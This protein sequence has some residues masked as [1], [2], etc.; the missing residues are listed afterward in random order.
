MPD[1]HQ[2]G[3]EQAQRSWRIFRATV[4]A[5]LALLFGA[6]GACGITYTSGTIHA[7]PVEPGNLDAAPLVLIVAIPA[8]VV[9]VLCF[10]GCA[11]AL[12]RELRR[13]SP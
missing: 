2:D 9:G 6:M 13:R 7:K 4:F 1:E 8:I 3:E 12:Y 5:L 10:I 11:S